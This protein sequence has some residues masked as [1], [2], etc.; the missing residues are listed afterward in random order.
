MHISY[1]EPKSQKRIRAHSGL[2]STIRDVR[3]LKD[4]KIPVTKE[5]LGLT[6]SDGKRQNIR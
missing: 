1:I 6:P 3:R 5:L 4:Q 2:F